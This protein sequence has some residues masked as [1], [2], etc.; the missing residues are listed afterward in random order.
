MNSAY[1]EKDIFTRVKRFRGL[2]GHEAERR[3]WSSGEVRFAF[4]SRLSRRTRNCYIRSSYVGR[5]SRS[6][7]FLFLARTVEREHCSADG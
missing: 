3:P 6:L 2:E 1:D 4:N 7:L 5:Q